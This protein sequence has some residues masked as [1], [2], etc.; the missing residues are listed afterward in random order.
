MYKSHSELDI[1]GCR[2]FGVLSSSNSGCQRCIIIYLDCAHVDEWW[3]WAECGVYTQRD[4]AKFFHSNA[5]VRF[6]RSKLSDPI[7][8]SPWYSL[9]VVTM[10][11]SDP[12]AVL[13]TDIYLQ[14]PSTN[15][16]DNCVCFL[17]IQLQID[18]SQWDFPADIWLIKPNGESIVKVATI[19]P[20]VLIGVLGNGLLL[21]IISRNRALRTPTNFLLANMAAADLVTLIFCPVMFICKD[22]FQIYQLGAIGCKLEGF[23]QGLSRAYFCCCEW[24]VAYLL[25]FVVC[26]SS[27]LPH[28]GGT[29]SMRR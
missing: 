27:C 3:T 16:D 18:V 25:R 7:T 14:L 26:V 5:L 19:L 21:N 2:V 4:I 8:P 28:H 15:N 23:I 20:V 24:L 12:E 6:N 17:Q 13:A 29:E 22:L 10:S 11:E 9:C 1:G